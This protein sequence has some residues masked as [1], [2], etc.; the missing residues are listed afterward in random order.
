MAVVK[1]MLNEDPALRPRLDD[2]LKSFDC[3][4]GHIDQS[5]PHNFS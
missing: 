3:M 2:V 1:P 4:L 5:C